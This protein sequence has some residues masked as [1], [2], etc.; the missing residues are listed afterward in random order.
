MA[1]T[2][3]CDIGTIRE[4]M[5]WRVKYRV[6][7]ASGNTMSRIPILM[8]GVH[9]SNRGGVYTSESD[10]YDLCETLVKKGFVQEEADHAGEGDSE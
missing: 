9:N 5:A 8:L 1:S 2:S 3:K 7:D 6:V 10:V 4:A